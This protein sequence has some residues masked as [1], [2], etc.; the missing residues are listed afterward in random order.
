MAFDILDDLETSVIE[1]AGKKGFYFA[2]VLMP[3]S[4]YSVDSSCGLRQ[5]I[6][7]W[8]SSTDPEAM[9]QGF[10]NT[11][12]SRRHALDD[13]YQQVS[14]LYVLIDRM[15]GSWQEA[16][17]LDNLVIVMHGDHGSRVSLKWPKSSD[18]PSPENSQNDR[19]NFQAH[20]AYR[21][22]DSAGQLD[23]REVG[24]QDWFAELFGAKFDQ[25]Y[26]DNVFVRDELTSVKGKMLNQRP[27]YGFNSARQPGAN[28]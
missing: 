21:T 12:E 19:D 16:G 15:L 20:F 25:Q 13:Y 4:P 9:K 10:E 11:M 8:T 5:P 28:E 23:Q 26:G 14:C 27:Y 17:L 1:N 18:Q 7:F 24:L 2:H 3:H 6:G 22:A